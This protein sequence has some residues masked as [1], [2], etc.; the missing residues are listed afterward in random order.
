MRLAERV[1]ADSGTAAPTCY[2][3]LL[4]HAGCTADAEV[5]AGLFDEGVL[6]RYFTPGDVRNAAGT[7]AD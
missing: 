4:F 5:A 7:L 6:V 2:G 3:C 1:G